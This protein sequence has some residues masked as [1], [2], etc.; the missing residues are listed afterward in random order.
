LSPRRPMQ[1]GR[2]NL[3]RVRFYLYPAK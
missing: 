2:A 1:C 3:A